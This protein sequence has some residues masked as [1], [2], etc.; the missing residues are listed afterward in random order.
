M[1]DD[2]F[3][4]MR[5]FQEVVLET[6][7]S[8]KNVILQAPTGSGKTRAALIPL[9]FN[10]AEWAADDPTKFP[11]KCIYSCLLYTSPSPRD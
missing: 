8:G 6:L 7:A 1:Q 4:S 2:L 5:F 10:L 11:R 3:D 9:L